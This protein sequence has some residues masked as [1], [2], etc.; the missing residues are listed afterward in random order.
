VKS[1]SSSINLETR[2]TIGARLVLIVALLFI[3][4]NLGH[5]L[6]RFTIPS[7]G[8]AGPDPDEEDLAEVVFKLETNAVGAP[9]G[10]QPGDVVVAIG[11]VPTDVILDNFPASLT[12]P[13]DWEVGE[14][15]TLTLERDGTRMEV[16][17]PVVQWTP[18]AWVKTELSNFEAVWNWLTALLLFGVGLFTFLRRPGNLAARFLFAFGV[19]SLSIGLS[20]SVPD[21]MAF[22][23][24]I[25]AGYAKVFFGNIIFAYLLGPSFLGFTLT[26]PHPKGFIRRWPRWLLVPYVVGSIT[27]LLLFTAPDLAVIGFLFTFWMML[28]GLASLI[29]AAVTMRDTISRAQLR[30]AVGGVFAGITLFMLNFVAYQP[31]YR[32]IILAIA[33]LGL[34]VIALSLAVAILRYRLFDIDILIRRTLS[35][36]ILT[37][38]LALTYFGGV[39]LLQNIFGGLFGNA[40]SPLITVITTLTIAAL[41]NP[42]RARIQ[43]FIDRRFFRSKYDAEKTLTEFAAV[44]RDEVD[45]VRL[46]GALLSVVESAMQPEQTSL[47]LRETTRRE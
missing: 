35:Y 15:I 20:F 6:Y 17:V 42:L 13:A 46:S 45:M 28:L 24:D 26:F 8:W 22:Y 38:L 7:I 23:L 14:T 36:A 18:A 31:K 39:V 2:W 29:H 40:E 43:N 41:F 37:T 47:W 32:E 1:K 4:L 30:W 34:P 44:A 9:S 21:P 12:V 5:V 11:E 19:A 27:I 3:G 25:F 33:D 16:G 10:L